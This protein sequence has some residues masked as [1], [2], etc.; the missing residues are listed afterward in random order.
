MSEKYQGLTIV[1]DADT[2]AAKAK[3]EELTAE[4]EKLVEKLMEAQATLRDLPL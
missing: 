2:T 3:L 4:A 1:I